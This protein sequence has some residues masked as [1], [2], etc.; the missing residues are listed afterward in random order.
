MQ[1]QQPVAME[2]KL[3]L[4]GSLTAA[5]P[6]RATIASIVKVKSDHIANSKDQCKS[7]QGAPHPPLPMTVALRQAPWGPEGQSICF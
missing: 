1:C 7:Y 2:E 4:A 6:N 3:H 5:N